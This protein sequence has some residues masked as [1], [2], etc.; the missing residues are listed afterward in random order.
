MNRGPLLEVDAVS[1]SYTLPSNRLF[2]RG[3]SVMRG[4]SEPVLARGES[5]GLVGETGCGKTSLSRAVYGLTPVSSGA[6]RFD[7]VDV[8]TASRTQRRAIRR[9]CR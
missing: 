9:G 7:G 4:S 2:R 1:V 6:I 5:L 3:R 8:G